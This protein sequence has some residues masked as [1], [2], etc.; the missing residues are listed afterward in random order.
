MKQTI[1]M[2][3]FFAFL[4]KN[5]RAL[6]YGKVILAA[7]LTFAM[8]GFASAATLTISNT[9]SSAPMKYDYRNS[10]TVV[11]TGTLNPGQSVTKTG[12]F[13][14]IYIYNTNNA[15]NVGTLV[16]SGGGS[17]SLM[18]GARSFSSIQSG[19]TISFCDVANTCPATTLNWGAGNYCAASAA[20]TDSGNSI[21]LTNSTPGASGSATASCSAGA[22]SVTPTSCTASLVA[23]SGLFATDGANS[24]SISISWG[25]S[26]GASTYR[27]QY[28]KQGASTWVDLTAANVTSYN[29][30]GLT[31]ESVFEFQV[32]A[33]NSVGSSA[34]SAI[35]TGFIRPAL[36]PAFVSQT[37]IPAKIG[38]GQTF[39]FSQVWK[40]NGSETWTGGAHGT[41][42]FNPA[43]TSVWGLGNVAFTGSTATGA[44]VTTNLTV[45]AP[46]TAGTYPLQRIFQKSGTP[47]GAASTLVNVIVVDTPACTGATP[48]IT[49]TYNPNGTFTV[50]L[51]GAYSVESATIKAWGN[52]NGRDDERS[53]AMTGS[54][55]S[56]SVTIPI[57]NHYT[58]GETQISFE[59]L[60]ANS[61]FTARVCASNSVAFQN[62]PVPSVTLTPT[63]G[64]YTLAGSTQGF[65]ASR[66][67]GEY[68]KVSVDLGTFSAMKTKVEFIAA[69][70]S[71]YG[72]NL[73][74]LP[75]GVATSMTML[76]NLYADSVPAWT[77]YTG[78]VRVTYADPEAALQGKTALVPVSVDIAPKSMTVTAS[79]NLGMPPSVD[80]KVHVANAYDPAAHGQ[81]LGGLFVNSSNDVVM[82]FANTGAQG[83]WK[84][85][86]LDYAAL[87]DKQLVA[88]A[89]A[90]PPSGV[91]LIAPIEFKSAVFTLP[92][93]APASVDATDGTRE[94]DVKV[95]WP[96]VATGSSIR[97]R[98]FRD[99]TEISN[100]TGIAAVEFI[101]VPPARGV[102]YTYAVKTM[103]GLASSDNQAQDGGF[104][105]GCR[106]A[107]L[108]G[109][110]LNADMTAISGLIERWECLTE[111]T[112][113]G[114]ID[115]GAPSPV[116]I[117]GATSY[118]SFSHAI[119]AALA[120]GAHV[121]HLG[122]ESQGVTLNSSRTYDIPFTLSRSA[123][124]I[125]NLT[126]IYDGATA[127][128]GL[129]ATSIGRFGVR[130]D[131]GAGLG[132]AEETK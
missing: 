102:T 97:Y 44:S 33:E 49:T 113:T 85:L 3:A 43:N 109:A 131:G 52:I 80:A 117:S 118:R 93:Q 79:G 1:L 48:S 127:Q 58:S 69:D 96:A 7:F 70:T 2:R 25:A 114:A 28:R 111:S 13:D 10:S 24:G 59:A 41:A 78:T 83:D 92:V 16:A 6:S 67:N 21:S 86:G 126:I 61:L 124:S 14:N 27:L 125:K 46:A 62:L 54:G 32:R 12:T 95:T 36:A 103:V 9:S 40:N 89:R 120:D 47:Y 84:A 73:N 17:C 4:D 56:W 71:A 51:V 55:A 29:W 88:I 65:V 64:S 30:T 19:D 106:A 11:F 66:S 110:T 60:V 121:L 90:V 23:P 45:T 38:V 68:A 35:E 42:P 57:A 82:P 15:A 104:M 99:G 100:P 122:I 105:P 123:I 107:R 26:S 129:E 119:D 22:W 81:F 8:F 50:S 76:A 20:V 63:V 75:S 31:D 72:V 112:A 101:D 94:D 18:Y 91:T 34:W 128:Q 37:G 5:L 98:V 108:V 132:F 77:R 53:Y 74:N 116:N 115:N 39:S 87:Y 130:M